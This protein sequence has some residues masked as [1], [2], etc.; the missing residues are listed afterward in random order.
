MLSEV[1]TIQT[2]LSPFLPVYP[3][4]A[5]SICLLVGLE[6]TLKSELSNLCKTLGILLRW[7]K[8]DEK[9]FQGKVL[10]LSLPGQF[11]QG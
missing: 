9:V 8:E 4:Q 3:D 11:T 10:S 1:T 2:G 6:F 5:S 7:K